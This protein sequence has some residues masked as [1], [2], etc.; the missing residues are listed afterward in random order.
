MATHF[1]SCDLDL[2]KAH[3]ELLHLRYGRP[4]WLTE[5]ACP[6]EDWSYTRDFL[7]AFMEWADAPGRWWLERYAWFGLSV[8][9]TQ[10]H[11]EWLGA[12][13]RAPRSWGRAWA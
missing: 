1:Y 2:L 5:F 3:L 11:Y 13:A 8:R 10:G 9:G 6:L 4:V 7:R 12:R